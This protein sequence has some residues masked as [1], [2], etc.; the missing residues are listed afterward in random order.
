MACAEGELL[1]E[2]AET[3]LGYRWA[4]SALG[5]LEQHHPSTGDKCEHFQVRLPHQPLHF[6]SCKDCPFTPDIDWIIRYA[7]R[8]RLHQLISFGINSLWPVP[9]LCR[10]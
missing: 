5:D 2:C 3:G 7:A 10:S 1:S 9:C 6:L 4:G 8:L